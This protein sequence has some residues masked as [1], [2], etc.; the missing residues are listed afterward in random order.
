MTKVIQHKIIVFGYQ[1]VVT[2][3]RTSVEVSASTV[4]TISESVLP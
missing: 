4:K 1:A 2:A 3:A